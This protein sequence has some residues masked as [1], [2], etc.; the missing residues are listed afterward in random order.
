MADRIWLVPPLAVT[1]FVVV[2]AALSEQRPLVVVAAAAVAVGGAVLL[3]R[4]GVPVLPVAVLV[5]L[6]V[7]VLCVGSSAN[8]GW[9]ALC[10]LAGV[11][12]LQGARP[13]V[14]FT[15]FA[16]VVFAV[17]WGLGPEWGWVTWVAGTLF[18]TVVCVMARRQHDLLQQLRAAQAGLADRARAEERNRIARELHDVIGHSL[19]VSLL[20]V[21]SAR[22][23]LQED[24]EEAAA[25]LEEAERLGRESLTEVRQAVGLLRAGDG[26]STAPM[27][28]TGQLGALVEGLRRAGTPVTY[29]VV[30]DPSGLSATAGLTVYRILQEA[31][32][33]VARHAPGVHV[34]V[35]LEL[36]SQETVLTIHSAGPPG[37]GNDEGVGLHSMHER[38]SA[39]G[40]A[41][42]AGPEATGWR[43]RAT[44]PAA[45]RRPVG[46]RR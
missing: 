45:P 6:A 22:L 5:S 41:V 38:A 19:T 4:D 15:V 21:S 43:V 37:P 39:M 8:L 9:F 7:A 44:L 40:G 16:T 35:R 46:A 2:G 27:P 13:G 12:S 11:C 20:H 28:G 31:L 42:V 30:G 1:L 17:M 32:T 25:A 23:A 18:T 24:P 36:A 29:E 14:V 3:A 10:V 33:N 26:S 34:D